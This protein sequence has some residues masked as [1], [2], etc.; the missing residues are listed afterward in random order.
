MVRLWPH[1]VQV[2]LTISNKFIKNIPL[3][4]GLTEVG[5]TENGRAQRRMMMMPMKISPCFDR[6]KEYKKF[7]TL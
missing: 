6:L 1:K 4:S 7:S 3:V 5:I 2:Y